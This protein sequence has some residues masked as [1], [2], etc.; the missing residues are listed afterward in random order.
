MADNTVGTRSKRS[1]QYM[2]QMTGYSAFIPE[3]LPPNPPID[4]DGEMQTLL[5][6]A[7]RALGRLDGSIQTLPNPDLF[8]FMYVRKEAVLSSQIEGTQSSLDDILEVEAKVLERRHPNDVDEVL[9]YVSSMKYG[10]ERLETLPLSV[11][12]I[13]EIHERLLNSVRGREKNPGEI[14]RTQNWIGPTGCTLRDAIFVP[15]PPNVVMDKLGALEN[16]MHAEVDIPILVK[17]GMIHAQFE[18]IHPFLDG[19]GRVGRLLITFLLCQNEI[20]IRPV[21]YI[22]Y[23]FKQNRSEYYERL[24]RVRDFGEWEAWIKFFLKG[25]SQVSLEA[26]ETARSIVGLREKHRQSITLEFGRA[27]GSGLQILEGLFEKPIT[28][29]SEVA[30]SLSVT[31][32]AANSL[33]QKFVELNILSEITGQKRNRV[34]RY[35]PYVDL[36]SES[37]HDQKNAVDDADF[38]GR[39]EPF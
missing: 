19:N 7:D 5:S 22:S 18:T 39:T 32:A 2:R 12:L 28:T 13:T 26:T 20:M 30:S 35:S 34:F 15:P 23:F 38:G 29:V 17:I 4:F 8:V 33:V 9:N 27:A 10:L 11:R 25:V 3:D 37:I 24:Q 21:L 14:R 16:F 6:K 1:G 36:F 31:Y